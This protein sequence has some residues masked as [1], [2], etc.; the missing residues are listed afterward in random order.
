MGIGEQRPR[1]GPIL[2]LRSPEIWPSQES[3]LPHPCLLDSYNGFLGFIVGKGTYQS[4]PGDTKAQRGQISCLKAVMLGLIKAGQAWVTA[5][6]VIALWGQPCRVEVCSLTFLSLSSPFS[7]LALGSFAFSALCTCLP[8]ALWLLSAFF[9]LTPLSPCLLLLL[10]P[11]LWLPVSPLPSSHL[12]RYNHFDKDPPKQQ[13]GS[14]G[15]GL[16]ERC[17]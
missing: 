12:L 2:A 7:L 14:S 1:L 6:T 8:L 16:L 4:E 9:P 10:T 17:P 3:P 11:V 13:G 5:P 15:H